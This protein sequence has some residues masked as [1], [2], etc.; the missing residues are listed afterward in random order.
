MVDDKAEYQIKDRLS[1]GTKV[2]DAKTIWAFRERRV[3]S[4]TEKT[5][6]SLFAEQMKRKGIIIR[7]GSIS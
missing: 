5:L 7:S 2:P 4:G 1:F 6:F 3:K